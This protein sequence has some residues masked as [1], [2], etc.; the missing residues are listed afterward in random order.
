[1][2]LAVAA[3]L[4]GSGLPLPVQVDVTG[5]TVGAAFTVTA[6]SGS[7]S[8]LVQG[9]AGGAASSTQ[10]LLTDIATPLNAPVTYT[11][12][13]GAAS[14]TSS[15]VTVAFPGD[16]LLQ[17]MDGRIVVPFDWQDNGDPRSMPPNGASFRPHGSTRA[18]HHWDVGSD[19]VGTIVAETDSAGTQAMRELLLAGGDVLY[20]TAPG[21]RDLEPVDVVAIT[22]ASRVLV[23]A[24]GGLRTWQL[25]FELSAFSDD[26]TPLVMVTFDHVNTVLAG[27]TLA[28]VNTM[29]AAWTFADVN[30]YDWVG[31]AS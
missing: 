10:A 2:A 30:A 6:S 11:V 13:Q 4:V 12:R 8:R 22:S 27:M 24:V 25:G 20:R 23:G 5:L 7:W 16:S 21:M 3:A 15:P 17:S 14:A 1:M 29:M 26:D 19:D 31:E 9:G 28:Q 18:L